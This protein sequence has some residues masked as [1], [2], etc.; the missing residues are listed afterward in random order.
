MGQMLNRALERLDFLGH[1]SDNPCYLVRTYL[2][3][4]NRRAAGCLLGWMAELGMQTQ[5]WSDGTVRGVLP[6][7][8]PEAKPL[9]LGS[10]LDT[11]TNAGKYDGALGLIAAL[12]ALEELR[13][14]G[15]QLPF[16]VHLLGFSDE[17]G[18]RFQTTYLGSRGVT[19]Q[20]AL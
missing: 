15:I 8:A 4:A 2:S 20:L 11:V 12:A 7:T 5:H 17:E 14:Q 6:G 18:V 16:P 13:D 3:P 1:I 9:L 10:H 19:G